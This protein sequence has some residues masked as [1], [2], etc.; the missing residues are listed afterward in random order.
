VGYRYRVFETVNDTLLL[1]CDGKDEALDFIASKEDGV[2]LCLADT[3]DMEV[4]YFD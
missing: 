4:E 3:K 1:A 2:P